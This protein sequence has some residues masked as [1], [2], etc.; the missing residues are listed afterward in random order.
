MKENRRNTNLKLVGL[1]VATVIGLSLLQLYITNKMFLR[2]PKRKQYF[3]RRLS[4]NMPEKW[5]V[6]RGENILIA[7]GPGGFVSVYGQDVN[8]LVQRGVVNFNVEDEKL[9][10]NVSLGGEVQISRKAFSRGYIV[11]SISHDDAR[12]RI[13]IASPM[14]GYRVERVEGGV[15]ISN[16]YL[17]V[18]ISRG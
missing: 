3:L 17:V 6:R 18:R 9:H 13:V 7:S 10:V 15:E 16:E 5:V 12:Y 11:F 14:I 4:G 8:L 1:A 2:I